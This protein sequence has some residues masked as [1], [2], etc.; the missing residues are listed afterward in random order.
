VTLQECS[1]GILAID[2]RQSPIHF[3]QLI[4]DFGAAHVSPVIWPNFIT[5]YAQ[6]TVALLWRHQLLRWHKVNLAIR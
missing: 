5:V 6:R 3:S 4:L 2:N 1:L